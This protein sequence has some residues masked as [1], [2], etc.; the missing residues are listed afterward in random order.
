MQISE[1]DSDTLLDTTSS[2]SDTSE[3]EVSHNKVEERVAQH[4]ACRA[5]NPLTEGEGPI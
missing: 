2:Y 1:S 5:W 4:L 3:T